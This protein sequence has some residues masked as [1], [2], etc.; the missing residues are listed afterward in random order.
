MRTLLLFDIDGTLVLSGRAGLRA[1]NRAFADEMG[2]ADAFAGISAAG[3]TDGYLLHEAARRAGLALTNAQVERLKLRY[4]HLLEEEIQHRGEGRKEVMPG[5]RPLIDTLQERDDVV[6][7]LLTGNYQ[8][9]ARIKLEHFDLW[10]PFGFG[11]FADD[12]TDR[13]LLVPVALH[14]AREAGHDPHVDRVIVIGD[15]PLDVQCAHAGGVRAIGVATGSHSID[16]LRDAGAYAAF[17]T[18]SETEQ[19][20]EALGLS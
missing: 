9:S 12:A 6:L 2:I 3:R 15:T 13:N 19:V 11:A 14:R 7:A 16:E 1:L 18:L 4:F 17:E 20:M 5:V 10:S 8:R